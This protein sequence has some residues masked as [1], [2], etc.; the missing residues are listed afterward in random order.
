MPTLSRSILPALTSLLLVACND[1]SA[2]RLPG[3]FEILQGPPLRAA[4]GLFLFDTLTVRLVDQQGL[5]IGGHAVAWVVRQGGGSVV[6]LQDE[7]DADGRARA[8]WSLGSTSGVNQLEV[9]TI[10]GAVAVTFQITGEAFRV[11]QLDSEYGLACGLLQG[12]AWCWGQDS[13][14]ESER[15]SD[16]PSDIFVQDFNAPGLALAGQQLVALAV[17]WPG[18]CAIDL[19]GLVRCFAPGSPPYSATPSVPVMR[20]LA[21]EQS[22]FCGVTVADS[23]AWCWNFMTGT[24]SQVPGSPAFLDIDVSTGNSGLATY[25]C[26]RRVD[27]TAVCWGDGPRGN[28]SL[29]PSDT[30]APVSGG[31]RFAQVSV[32]W[33]FACGRL[34]NGELWCWGQNDLGQLGSPG[35]PSAVPVLVTTGVTL[36]AAADRTGIAI[37][38]GSVVRWGA[39]QFGSALGSHPGLTGMPVTDFAES[40]ISCA[41]LADRQVYCY[42][43]LWFVS[44]SF[45]VDRYSPVQPV[46]VP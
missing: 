34:D 18:G 37:R 38:N 15:V 25:G 30:I 32:G 35:Q 11:D 43:E 14:V 27:S 28:G 29:V 22:A 2:S 26:G 17:G 19:A 36:V 40:D 8:R 31:R 9:R 42:D 23:T 1:P 21:A 33:D 45:D 20:Q 12:D 10:D 6:P 13:W 39:D 41:R 24:G 44:S 16:Q 46:V 7:T 5:P 3:D 4:P